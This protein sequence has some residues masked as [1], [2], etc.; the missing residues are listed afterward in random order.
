MA[1][2]ILLLS[3][4]AGRSLRCVLSAAALFCSGPIASALQTQFLVASDVHTI[5]AQGAAY[6][7]AYS[8]NSVLAVV[9]RE[10]YVLGVVGLGSFAQLNLGQGT[11]AGAVSRAGTAA[12]L[13]SNENAFT[14]RTAGYIIQQHFPPGV[15][16][17][18]PGPLVGVGFSNLFFSDVNCFKRIGGGSVPLTSLADSPGGVPLYKNGELVGGIGVTGDSSPSNLSP[19]AFLLDPSSVPPTNST[20]GYKVAGDADE[21][22]ALAAQKGYRPSAKILATNVLL[23]GV[24]IPYVVGNV[25]RLPEP[26]LPLPLNPG[27]LLTAGTVPVDGGS[28]YALE[29][30]PRL[31][32]TGTILGGVA[33]E[34]RRIASGTLSNPNGTTPPGF[35]S[36]VA[37]SLPSPIT[38]NGV[39]AARLSAPEVTGILTLAAQRCAQ[40]RAGIRLPVGTRAKVWITVVNNPNDPTGATAPAVLGVFRVGEATMFSWDVSAQKARTALFF[41][42]A[43]MAMSTRAVGFLAQRFFPPG[44]DGRAWGPLF[45][46]QEA[47]SLKTNGAGNYP[48]TPNLPNGMT[49]FPGG[50]PLY[51]NGV[52]I[53]A[54]GVSGDGVDQDDMVCASGC[55]NFLAPESIRSDRAIYRGARLPYVKFPRN[56]L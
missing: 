3:N 41:S 23:G 16:N 21:N 25:S 47:V 24:R 26:P 51:R 22:V 5:M 38:I 34:Y 36:P 31:T 46:L 7:A 19:A 13:S 43:S 2:G 17:T 40:I 4:I 15:R 45:G 8:P 30:S 56:P 39:T 27:T 55:A 42:D 29:G 11:I 50:L 9:D 44:L 1:E 49:I 53:G 20:A 10:G 6:A 33:G 48:G 32:Y 28:L 18:S 52:L 14:S 37:D 54:I 35:G 12:Y